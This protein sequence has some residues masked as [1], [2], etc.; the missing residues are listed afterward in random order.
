MIDVI[1]YI[2][3]AFTIVISAVF[4]P[5]PI[6]NE[7]TTVRRLPYVTFVIIGLNVLIF[8]ATI[9]T[10]SRQSQEIDQAARGVVMLLGNHPAWLHDGEKV[11]KLV[12][13]GLFPPEAVERLKRG[14]E[15][16][17]SPIPDPDADPDSPTDILGL[18]D[19]RSSIP[20]DVET[21]DDAEF[22]AG[23]ARLKEAVDSHIWFRFGL[24]PNGNWK[25]YQPF[26]AAFLHV[27]W[28][29]LLGN[30]LF[31]FAVAFSLEDLWGRSVFLSF[32]LVAAFA[33][34]LPMLISPATV[35]SFGAS[36]AVSAVMGAF[37]IRLY[38]TKIKVFWLSIPYMFTLLF[39]KVKPFGV[40]NIPAYV[41]LPFFFVTQ[42][43]HWWSVSK[44]HQQSGVAYSVHVAGF[45]FGALFALALKWSKLEERVLNPKIESK[46]SFSGS[47]DVTTAME[48]IDQ[49]ELAQAERKLQTALARNP[50][51]ID[52]IMG[53]IHVHQQTGDTHSL[54][55]LY[56]RVIRYHLA[57]GD[58]EAALY[59]YD[60][61]LTAAPEGEGAVQIPVRD[62]FTICEYLKS[63]GMGKEASVEFERLAVACADTPFA[64]RACLQGGEAAQTAGDYARAQKL[65]EL[66][67]TMNPTS[68]LAARLEAALASC[69]GRIAELPAW[70]QPKDGGRSNAH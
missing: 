13:T 1:F 16:K 42:A 25:I 65:F 44:N 22:D 52:A 40:V 48:L 36:G 5:I 66:G 62:W 56:G 50:E 55:S 51:D 24:A 10:V 59:A 30:M 14:L 57:H 37:L 7:N 8:V 11:R 6:G 67:S 9:P 28:M 47:T 31:L 49:G 45:L 4:M 18:D 41:F 27:G 64:A 61:L 26:T 20:S 17:R 39:A 53:L 46:I 58:K 29:H 3:L 43:L 12:D 35:P 21:A 2:I 38:K 19:D 54:N 33:A 70:E 68:P 69:H 32:Y 34:C 63:A 15:A 60:A 23:V